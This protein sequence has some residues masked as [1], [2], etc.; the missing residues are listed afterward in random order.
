MK[1]LL[2][3]KT[4]RRTMQNRSRHSCPS[5]TDAVGSGHDVRYIALHKRDLLMF[6]PVATHANATT[7]KCYDMHACWCAM[8]RLNLQSEIG[9]DNYGRAMQNGTI[10]SCSMINKRQQL[11][12]AAM[13]MIGTRD[14]QSLACQEK[15][16]QKY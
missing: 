16:R 5:P 3:C 10:F 14:M 4:D 6:I 8:T 1:Y 13:L 7:C 11:A 9:K 2:V 12:I 15:T